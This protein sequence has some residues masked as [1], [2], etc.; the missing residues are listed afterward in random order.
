MGRRSMWTDRK[1]YEE[2]EKAKRMNPVWRGVGCIM[3]IVLGAVGYFFAGWFIEQGIVYFPPE[4]IR[5]SFAPFLPDGVFVQIVISLIFMVLS[6]SVVNIIW[7]VMFPKKLGETDAPPL[8][9][10]DPT[11][12]RSF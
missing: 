7:A 2:R 1:F 12:G 3:V 5:P 8:K 11:I 10:K 6:F 9:K 4:V